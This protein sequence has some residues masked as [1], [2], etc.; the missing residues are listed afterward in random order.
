MKCLVLS[1]PTS[2]DVD[3]GFVDNR[4]D[5]CAS[6]EVSS[7]KQLRIVPTI[8]F[9]DADADVA[10][11][12]DPEEL[13]RSADAEHKFEQTPSAQGFSS[14][15]I[16]PRYVTEPGYL[17]RRSPPAPPQPS[18]TR[19]MCNLN[20]DTIPILDQ[21]SFPDP[22]GPEAQMTASTQEFLVAWRT[23]TE[24]QLQGASLLG[25]A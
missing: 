7:R 11:G 25:K 16:T 14:P 19:K 5:M 21:D 13:E 1:D 3:V 20:W 10:E 12:V 2:S 15:C 17:N 4:F 18:E 9:L 8:P 22:A 23:R 6:P 24:A